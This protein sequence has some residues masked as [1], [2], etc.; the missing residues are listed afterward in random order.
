MRSKLADLPGV[1]RG[2]VLEEQLVLRVTREDR[3]RLNRAAAEVGVPAGR[4]A[5][6]IL[7]HVLGG[8]TAPA[9]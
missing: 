5:R 6:A 1:R 3:E 9:A 2:E 7:R 8:A 4:L